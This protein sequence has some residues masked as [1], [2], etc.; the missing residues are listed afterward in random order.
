MLSFLRLS[1]S[2]LHSC[3]GARS[4][5]L[6][7][8]TSLLLAHPPPL[9]CSQAELFASA[10]LKRAYTSRAPHSYSG[11]RYPHPSPIQSPSALSIYSSN[12]YSYS[13]SFAASAP[14]SFSTSSK[15]SAK[16]K[17]SIDSIPET[18]HAVQFSKIGGPEVIEFV[19]I[20]TPVPTPDEF[21]IK[22]EYGGVNYSQYTVFVF[23]SRFPC[24][25]IPVAKIQ[26]LSS[27]STPSWLIV[28]HDDD[29]T[30]LLNHCLSFGSCSRHLPSERCV[31]SSI[32]FH[33]RTRSFGHHCEAAHS[34]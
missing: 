10:S 1:L 27:T 9:Y 21:L 14:R 20:P 4:T 8:S 22:V 24:I 30:D 19:Q 25:I 5:L 11:H 15:L 16:D 17:M 32:T 34:I 23:F 12:S 2:S 29:P 7:S 31:Q 18:T 3:T 13:Y 33:D 6:G 28:V 26:S